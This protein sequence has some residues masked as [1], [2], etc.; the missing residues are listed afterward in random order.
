MKL[1]KL[2]II[3][4]FISLI[5][6][7]E[8]ADSLAKDQWDWGWDI[9]NYPISDVNYFQER[10]SSPKYRKKIYGE[11]IWFYKKNVSPKQGSRCP[12]FPSCSTYTLYSMKEY[13]FFWGFIMGIERIYIRENFDVTYR[14]HYV[15]IWINGKEKVYDPPEA[16]YL[17]GKKD[18]RIVNPI[19]FDFFYK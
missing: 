2:I 9:S 6:I 12:C 19:Y 5:S 16:N 8:A 13:G 1:L 18:W 3:L 4:C 7:V 10:V 15:P 11:I 17:F 14:I